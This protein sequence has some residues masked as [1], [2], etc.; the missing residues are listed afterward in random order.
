MRGSGLTATIGRHTVGNALVLHARDRISSEA[1]AL[2]LAVADDPHHDIVVLDLH[3][4]LPA[5]IWE[6]VAAALP[7]GRRGIRLMVCGAGQDVSSLAG[8]WL[9]D[10]LARPVVVP[11]GHLIRGTAGA[12]FVH[13]EHESGW[14]RHTPGRGPDWDGKRHPRPAW[15]GAAA[16]YLPTSAYGVSEPLPGGVWLRDTRDDAAVAEHWQWLTSAVPCQPQAFTVVLGCPGTPPLAL[17]DV[18]RFWHGLGDEGRDY[19]RFVHYGPVRVPDG[20]HVGQALADVLATQVVCFTGVPVGNPDRPRMHTVTP[21]GRLGWQVY[22]RE[23]AYEPRS[24]PS[25]KARTPKILSY[26]APVVLGEPV[27]PMVYRYTDDA[28]VE[29]VQ[30]GLWIRPPEVPRHAD[31]IRARP[32][33]PAGHAVVVDDAVPAVV[34]RLRA[35]A[36]DLVARLDD[37]TRERSMLHLA[38]TVAMTTNRPAQPAGGALPDG[39]TYRFTAADLMLHQVAEEIHGPTV[40][41]P[42]LSERKR[43]GAEPATPVPTVAPP[44]SGDVPLWQQG[45]AEPQ[46]PSRRAAPARSQQPPPSLTADVAFR[47]LNSL[48]SVSTDRGLRFQNDPPPA[49]RGIPG[50]DGLIAER[51]WLRE[52][53]RQEFD[54]AAGSVSR[55]LASHAGFHAGEDTMTDAVAVRLYLSPVA[56]GLDAALRGGE[57]GPHVPFARC[58]AAGLARLPTHRGIAMLRADLSTADLAAISARRTLTEWGFTNALT[59]PAA[60]LRGSVDILIWSMTGR[61]TRLLEFGDGTGVPARVLFRPGTRFKVLET[62]Q[63][64]LLLR[65]LS[66]EESDRDHVPFD[67]LAVSSLQRAAEQWAVSGSPPAALDPV[68]AE[69]FSRVPGLAPAP[70]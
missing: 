12:L 22:T 21:D 49:A 7:R 51:R 11:Y 30:S 10:R 67:D 9:S 27:A 2:A 42:V 5:G 34:P 60:A 63:R 66:P 25:A 4:D 61:R 28:V 69:R 18:A 8:Q 37:A 15:D 47:V 39:A 57:P 38:S 52:E 40:A 59:E 62:A 58:V 6:S 56:A 70:Y 54:A 16:T 65:E 32:A 26:R 13:A 44:V 3:D 24:G 35:L 14:I 36:D 46:L 68:A 50:Q 33:D 19:A 43:P 48:Q 17:D 29:I 45:P 23:L 41:L 64:R 55:V 20:D 31:L 53:L 1:Q